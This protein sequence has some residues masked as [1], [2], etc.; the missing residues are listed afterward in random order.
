MDQ[1]TLSKATLGGWWPGGS[2]DAGP[3]LAILVSYDA[4]PPLSKTLLCCS[5]CMGPG[6]N[7]WNGRHDA[8]HGVKY[9]GDGTSETDENTGSDAKYYFEPRKAHTSLLLQHSVRNR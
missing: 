7:M 4:A 5:G 2:F 8:E 1:E 6:Q 3:H 9:G